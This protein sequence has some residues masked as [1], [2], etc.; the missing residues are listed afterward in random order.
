[1]RVVIVAAVVSTLCGVNGFSYAPPSPVRAQG[2][3][4]LAAVSV[5]TET[6]GPPTPGT[7]EFPPALSP[8]QRAGRA[9]K[10]YS[11]VLPVLAAYQ[12]QQIKFDRQAQAG[13]PVSQAEQDKVWAE[14]DEW[15]STRIADTITDLRGFYVKTGQVIS[16]RVD[17]FPPAYTS[18]LQ[19]LQD[20][21]VHRRGLWELQ[22][23][24]RVPQ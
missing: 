6:A 11:K 8:L 9:L 21:T 24:P 22:P 10:F 12:V 17:L 5:P 18:K 13:Y 20:G 3:R 16:T 2:S 15:G 7:V 4:S 23:W 1:M 19:Q 14:I